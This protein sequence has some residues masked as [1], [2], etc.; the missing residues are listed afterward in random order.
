M[1]GPS[2]PNKVFQG[3]RFLVVDDEPDNVGVV[4]KLL[5]LLGGEVESAENGQEGLEHARAKQPDVILADLSMPVMS[6]WELLYQIR[7]DP[8]LKEIPVIALTAH[9]MSG[10]RERVLAAGF[11]SYIAK[12]I[13]VPK[14]VPALVSL[15]KDLQ[16]RTKQVIL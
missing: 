1:N 11:A 16:P 4:V 9:A 12:P 13:D 3:I 15:L 2:A 8:H 6:G 14:F 10:D 7:Q 5:T